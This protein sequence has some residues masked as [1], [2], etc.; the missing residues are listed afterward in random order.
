[1]LELGAGVSLPGLVAA[2]LG[3]ARVTLSDRADCPTIQQNAADAIEL[4]EM[5]NV[6]TAPLTWGRFE[7][8]FKDKPKVRA[9]LVP[10]LPSVSMAHNTQPLAGTIS[11]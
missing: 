9:S 1:M 4:N 8:D 2:R 3:A 7:G 10:P 11:T 5:T 6:R